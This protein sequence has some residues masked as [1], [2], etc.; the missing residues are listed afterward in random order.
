MSTAV[1][2][3]QRGREEQ[4]TSHCDMLHA[5]DC[6]LMRSPD[7]RL[8]EERALLC[9]AASLCCCCWLPYSQVARRVSKH[10]LVMCSPLSQHAWLAYALCPAT[11]VSLAPAA[12]TAAPGNATSDHVAGGAPGEAACCMPLR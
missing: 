8:C 5:C 4:A 7:A 9:V 12:G 6:A 3:R 2:A 10:Y 11:R 1:K